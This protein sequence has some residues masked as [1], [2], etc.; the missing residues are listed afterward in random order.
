[1]WKHPNKLNKIEDFSK[2]I[3]ID[4]SILGATIS[5]DHTKYIFTPSNCI[6]TEETS[7]EYYPLPAV[8]IK[9]SE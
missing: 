6:V 2:P 5:D 3:I 4:R 1:M 8:Y 9:T 7:T